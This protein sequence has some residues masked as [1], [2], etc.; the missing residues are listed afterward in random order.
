MPETL[1]SDVR[2]AL[3][4]RFRGAFGERLHRLI[5]YGSYARGEA[6]P[7]SDID[8]LVVLDGETDRSDTEQVHEVMLDLRNE[9]GAHVSPLVTSRERFDTYNQPLYRNVRAE[10]ELL[11][12]ADEPQAESALHQ[13]TYPQ[14]VSSRGMQEATEDALTRAQNNLDG[15]RR[16]FEAEDYNRAVSGAYYAMLYAARA[17]LNEAGEAPKS[18]SGVQHQLRETY[19]KNGP[20][21][22]YYHS[23]LSRAE[24]DRLDAD[25][26]LSPS[27][28]AEDAEQWI[29]RAEDFVETIEAMLLDSS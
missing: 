13:H 14:N 26:E 18:H 11:V 3:R 21:D 2:N 7:R 4:D 12:P 19:V 16:D 22:P 15:A 8:V 9:Y 20:L 29:T 10:G 25:Y 23:L 28:S 17:A 27:F 5:L 24:G 1:A 6:T